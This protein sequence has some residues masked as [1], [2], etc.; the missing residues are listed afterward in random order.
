MV[1]NGDQA[2][3]MHSLWIQ[4]RNNS[5]TQIL[6]NLSI[7]PRNIQPVAMSGKFIYLLMRFSQAYKQLNSLAKLGRKFLLEEKIK[8][9]LLVTN[10]LKK[11]TD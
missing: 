11:G 6:P 7:T 5:Y 8:N 9:M 4:K 1:V 2:G 3:Q 10:G